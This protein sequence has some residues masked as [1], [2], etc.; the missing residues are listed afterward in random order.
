MVIFCSKFLSTVKDPTGLTVSVP[1]EAENVMTE[2][3][4]FLPVS[5]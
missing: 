3:F 1:S 2:G 4:A 5:L